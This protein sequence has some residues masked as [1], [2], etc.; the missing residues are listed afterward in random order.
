MEVK[1]NKEIDMNDTRFTYTLN[2]ILFAAGLSLASFS[3]KTIIPGEGIEEV[4]Q[5]KA[6]IPTEAPTKKK[7]DEPEPEPLKVVTAAV[8]VP[9]INVAA[10]IT[11]DSKAVDNTGN[12]DDKIK[13]G[14]QSSATAGSETKPVDPIPEDAKIVEEEVIELPEIDPEFSGGT[15]NGW[16]SKNLIYPPIAQE[17]NEEGT[18]TVGFVVEKDG[19][20][21]NVKILRTSGSDELDQE[22]VSTVRRMPSWK[23]GENGGKKVRSKF[24]VKVAFKLQ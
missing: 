22:A 10:A 16:L 7:P 1:K 11:E 24:Q 20:L 5:E 15:V 23:A 2:G 19:K 4:E 17:N 9:Q 8:V 3:Y 18:A 21:S 13:I 6:E 14:E 12:V